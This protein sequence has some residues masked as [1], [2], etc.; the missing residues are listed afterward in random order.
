MTGAALLSLVGLLAACAEARYNDAHA[1]S[2]DLDWLAGYPAA[3]SAAAAAAV[4]TM[5]VSSLSTGGALT[6]QHPAWQ[7]SCRC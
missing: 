4:A 5:G 2:T 1:P 3:N 7:C 6:L